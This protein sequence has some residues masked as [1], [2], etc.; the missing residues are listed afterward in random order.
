MNTHG[1]GQATEIPRPSRMIE[2]HLLMSNVAQHRDISDPDLGGR[3]AV[4]VYSSSKIEDA[5]GRWSHTRV[6]LRPD[7]FDP[8][9]K[10]IVI[11]DLED[12]DFAIVAEYVASLG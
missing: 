2:N 1:A 7:S 10:P 11:E 4:K 6:E 5:E 9:F 12:G 3:Y 8:A